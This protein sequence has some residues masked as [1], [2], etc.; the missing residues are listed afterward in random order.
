MESSAQQHPS[1]INLD[2]DDVVAAAA[3]AAVV[4][5]DG[6]GGGRD[7]KFSVHFLFQ[8]QILLIAS[9]KINLG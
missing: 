1:L 7:E 6:G 4:V 8:N 9:S 2:F 3:D 5:V